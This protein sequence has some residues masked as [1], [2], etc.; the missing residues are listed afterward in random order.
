[1]RVAAAK[2]LFLT[3]LTVQGVLFSVAAKAA[4]VNFLA[5]SDNT[6]LGNTFVLNSV[7]FQSRPGSQAFVNVFND[8]NGDP[9]HGAQFENDGIQVILPTA[10]VQVDIEI[11]VFNTPGVGI[12]GLDAAGL[13]VDVL[14][15]PTDDQ[16]H[17]VTLSSV[18]NPIAFLQ[19][20]G[21][22][23]EAVINEI[24]N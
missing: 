2:M 6:N 14:G 19:L 3:L 22:G 24:C 7:T 21:G 17:N 4:C 9:V 20:R 8:I 18:G 16:L 10:S 1:M 11:G 5:F 12:R 13:V 15:V 23:N